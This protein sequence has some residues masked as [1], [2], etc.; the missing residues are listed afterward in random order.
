MNMREP[1][2]AWDRAPTDKELDSFYGKD[3]PTEIRDL[4]IETITQTVRTVSYKALSVPYVK[5]NPNGRSVIAPYSLKE[6]VTDYGTDPEPLKA[7][8]AVLEGSDCP[9]VA[10]WRMA[11]AERFVDSNADE[12]EELKG[13]L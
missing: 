4:M 5:N 3:K 1:T 6:V 13:E 2:T 10:A 7:L 9:L 8:L 11:M 12:V